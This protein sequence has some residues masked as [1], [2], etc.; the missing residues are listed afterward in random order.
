MEGPF[1]TM[2]SGARKTAHD[3]AQPIEMPTSTMALVQPFPLLDGPFSDLN[4]V[5]SSISKKGPYYL[6]KIHWKTENSLE[7]NS[8]G[9]GTLR[10]S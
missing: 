10:G 4:G 3:L 8:L 2:A 6:L 5:F 9:K 1:C 7:N